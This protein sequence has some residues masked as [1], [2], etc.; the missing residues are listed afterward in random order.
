MPTFDDI[1][2]E[3]EGVIVTVLK[4]DHDKKVQLSHVWTVDRR[5]METSDYVA[6]FSNMY[7]CPGLTSCSKGFN[8]LKDAA[9]YYDM[10]IEEMR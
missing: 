4:V 8:K 10:L 6:S 9:D 1:K 7:D 3:N 2:K 5:G